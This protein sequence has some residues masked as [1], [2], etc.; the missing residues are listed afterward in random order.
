[1]DPA[2]DKKTIRAQP[3]EASYFR[4]L[5]SELKYESGITDE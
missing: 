1:M 5:L 4:D 3:R 2:T